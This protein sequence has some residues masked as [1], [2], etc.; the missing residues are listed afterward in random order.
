[1]Y[2]PAMEITRRDLMAGCVATAFAPHAL[3]AAPARRPNIV[4]ILAD[5]LGW[6]N[7]SCYG[8]SDF[9]TPALDRL[10]AQGVRLTQA[11]ANSCVCSPTRMA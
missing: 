3:G 4:F 11:Y 5:D 10:A 7:L 1:M 2:V 8:N 9:A 6:G